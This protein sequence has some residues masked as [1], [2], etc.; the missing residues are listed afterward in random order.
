[1]V[2]DS[3]QLSGSTFP[4]GPRDTAQLGNIMVRYLKASLV[5]CVDIS[6]M[7]DQDLHSARSD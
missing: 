6:G 4:K 3:I 1:M 7:M 5:L 2:E